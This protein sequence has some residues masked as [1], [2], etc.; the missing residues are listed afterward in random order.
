M[1]GFRVTLANQ[2]KRP[3]VAPENAVDLIVSDIGMPR[4]DGFELLRQ[5]R[6]LDHYKTVPAIALTG[7]ATPKD[8]KAGLIAYLTHISNLSTCRTF[9]TDQEFVKK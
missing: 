4:M 5:L 3:A 1:R 6:E 9:E 8:E 2:Q 7:Y